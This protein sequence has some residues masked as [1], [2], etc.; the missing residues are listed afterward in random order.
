LSPKSKHLSPDSARSVNGVRAIA[1]FE[2]F[3]G[4]VILLVGFGL[5]H[6]LHHDI[7]SIAEELVRH[8]H[9]NPAHHYPQIFIEAAKRTDD[10]RVW[11]L[12]IT[13]FIYSAA[14]LV[15]AWGLWHL[16][17][18][19]QWFAIVSGGI[20]I[21]IEVAEIIKRITVLRIGVLAVNAFIVI[22]LIYIRWSKRPRSAEQK[23]GRNGHAR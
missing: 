10:S 20:Y 1:I 15:E 5:L 18:W 3:K 11:F 9:L 16:K 19:A 22:Y 2:A 21:P 23:S 6:F 12:A 4:V 13:A 14:R 8:S 7:Q 17:S